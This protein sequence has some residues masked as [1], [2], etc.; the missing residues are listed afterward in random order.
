MYVCTY[1]GIGAKDP[2]RYQHTMA[3]APNEFTDF[4]TRFHVLRSLY[5]ELLVSAEQICA[6]QIA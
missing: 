4:E 1:N 5:T 2:H 3:L 6:W